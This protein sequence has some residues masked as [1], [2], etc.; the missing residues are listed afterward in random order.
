[1]RALVVIVIGLAIGAIVFLAT[2]G[3]VIFLP[4]VFIPIAL[5]WPL[6]RRRRDGSL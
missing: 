4:F 3:R 6:G 1:V 2:G 5:L